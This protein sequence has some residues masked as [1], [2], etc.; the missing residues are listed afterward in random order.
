MGRKPGL[1]GEKI[2]RIISILAANTDGLWLRELARK[3]GFTHATVSRYVTSPPLK[4]LILDDSVGKPDKPALRLIRLKPFVIERL[5]QGQDINQI[6][7]FTK[8]MNKFG[9]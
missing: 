1:N 6:V 5:Q 2:G 8:L 4:A 7:K 9:Q 3:C